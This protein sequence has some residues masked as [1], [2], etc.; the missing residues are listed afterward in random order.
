MYLAGLEFQAS[1]AALWAIRSWQEASATRGNYFESAY[2]PCPVVP[3]QDKLCSG[4]DWHVPAGPF[5]AA[6]GA[7]GVGRGATLTPDAA[8]AEA[9]AAA[10]AAPAAAWAEAKA[11]AV[12]PEAAAVAVAEADAAADAA[13]C[14]QRHVFEQSTASSAA[15]RRRICPL[16]RSI[17]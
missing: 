17:A 6:G 14:I 12:L 9:E 15:G 16:Y 7:G 11:D 4:A 13:A 3:K 10:L 1:D 8:E 5:A 2:L